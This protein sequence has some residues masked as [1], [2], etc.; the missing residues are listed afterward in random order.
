VD[1]VDG[2]DYDF[3]IDHFVTSCTLITN[4]KTS[5]WFNGCSKCESDHVYGYTEENGV[6]FDRCL[7]Y[8]NGTTN[9]DC[10][11]AMTEEVTASPGTF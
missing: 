3:T 9:P 8:P 4:C 5:N 6:Q 11:S 1:T 2:V 10:F 7:A